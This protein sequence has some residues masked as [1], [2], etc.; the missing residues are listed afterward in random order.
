[1]AA[2][3]QYNSNALDQPMVLAQVIHLAQYASMPQ[4]QIRALHLSSSGSTQ[5]SD[6][7]LVVFDQRAPAVCAC[8]KT[9][10]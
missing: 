1:M 9:Q 4:V 6:D 2:C 8:V 3:V 10:L 7:S 5:D